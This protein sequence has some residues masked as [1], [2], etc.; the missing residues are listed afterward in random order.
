MRVLH[1]GAEIYPL[2]KTGGLG[3]VLGALPQALAERG[4]DVRLLVPGYPAIL[5][6]LEGSNVVAQ[7]GPAFGAASIVVRLGRLKGLGVPTYVLDAPALFD[8]PGNPYVAAD[9]NAWRDNPT[10]FGALSWVA[11]HLGIGDI[12]RAWRPAIV[13]GHDWHAGL[14]CAYL[15]QH[16]AP[17]CRSVFTIHNLAFHGLFEKHQLGALMLEAETFAFNGLEFHGQGSAIKAGLQ[18]ASRITTVSPTYAREITTPEF[19]CGLEAVVAHRRGL[20]AGILNGVDYAVWNPATDA[21][22]DTRFDPRGAPATMRAGKARAKEALQKQVGLDV[23]ADRL[24]IGVVSRLTPQKGIDLLLNAL[25]QVIPQGVQFVMLGSGDAPL[26][27]GMTA[28][29]QKHPNAVALK[30]GYDEAFAH[31]IMAGSDVIAVPSRF[32]PCGLTQLYALR[33][34]ALPLVRRVGGLADTVVDATETTL[35]NGAA[36]G[37]TFDA[38]TAG[39]LV[40]T[41]RRALKTYAAPDSWLAMMRTAVAQDFSWGKAAADYQAIYTDLTRDAA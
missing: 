6:A 17:R 13:H 1:V 32:E 30:F 14:A 22:L 11:A 29:A 33:Y 25:P 38:A 41:I 23:A 8:R 36:T 10:R 26:E 15:A 39:D 16:P 18:Y 27:A 7:V 3:D 19:G 21:L 5:A 31:R 4:T 37:F 34:G 24:L 12:D 40:A 35:A 20:L 28:L 2:V 9:G